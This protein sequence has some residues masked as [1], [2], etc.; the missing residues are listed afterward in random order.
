MKI[1][2]FVCVALS[3]LFVSLKLMGVITW[4]WLLALAPAGVYVAFA[5]FCVFIFCKYGNVQ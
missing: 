4:P 2:F 3:A 5:L 1:G